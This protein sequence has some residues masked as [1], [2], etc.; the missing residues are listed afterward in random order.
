MRKYFNNKKII[1]QKVKKA[2]VRIFINNYLNIFPCFVETYD[3]YTFNDERSWSMLK[4]LP[5][6][7]DNEEEE[8]EEDDEEDEED[9]EDDEEE[10]GQVA[11]N[12][13]DIDLKNMIT[14]KNISEKRISGNNYDSEDNEMFGIS[15][16]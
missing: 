12:P 6:S 4:N 15:C 8:D 10:K 7:K 9:E 13:N 5:N 1:Q 2:E 14:R 16:E 3:C 11:T